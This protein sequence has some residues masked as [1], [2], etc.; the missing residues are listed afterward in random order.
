M[1]NPKDFKKSMVT[2]PYFPIPCYNN[3][4]QCGDENIHHVNDFEFGLYLKYLVFIQLVIPR[5]FRLLQRSCIE[6]L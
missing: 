4:N 3:Q 5:G 6:N 2:R 1:E